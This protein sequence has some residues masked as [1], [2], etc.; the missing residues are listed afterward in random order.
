MPPPP[1]SQV[2][3]RAAQFYV[4]KKYLV[5]RPTGFLFVSWYVLTTAVKYFGGGH[6]LTYWWPFSALSSPAT[7]RPIAAVS[8]S[9]SPVPVVL[10]ARWTPRIIGREGGREAGREGGRLSFCEGTAAKG[11]KLHVQRG[12][13]FPLISVLSLALHWGSPNTA[14]CSPCTP[15][16]IRRSRPRTVPSPCPAS[17]PLAG[18]SEP[19]LF[20]SP[21]VGL[22]AH[23]LPGVA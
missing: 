6:V 3:H 13:A 10:S 12:P 20:S 1:Q 8:A 5:K 18:S 14:R 2:C 17:G 21:T 4:D 22:R 15:A 11:P 9:G 23:P 19:R 16:R 7:G